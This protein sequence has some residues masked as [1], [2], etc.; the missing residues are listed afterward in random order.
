ML[1]SSLVIYM[2]KLEKEFVL[3]F[4][5]TIGTEGK[6]EMFSP[7]IWGWGLFVTSGPRDKYIVSA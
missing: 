6:G 1:S 7:S 5:K 3:H 2:F 4:S